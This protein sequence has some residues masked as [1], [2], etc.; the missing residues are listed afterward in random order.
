MV[1]ISREAQVGAPVR[2]DGPH[3]G[4]GLPKDDPPAVRGTPVEGLSP[5][6]RAGQDTG[7]V[8]PTPP[9]PRAQPQVCTTAPRTPVS[10]ALASSRPGGTYSAPTKRRGAMSAWKRSR[11]LLDLLSMQ[12]QEPF[13]PGRIRRPSGVNGIIHVPKTTLALELFLWQQPGLTLL[14][15]SSP[16]CTYS[17]SREVHGTSVNI[18]NGSI[19]A[20]F[21]VQDCKWYFYLLLSIYLFIKCIR[22]SIKEEI[23]DLMTCTIIRTQR[24]RYRHQI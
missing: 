1:L 21:Q 19:K 3:L 13:S 9:P 8:L 23:R 24:F 14:R 18:N 4:R 17:T 7:R 6:C 20:P 10:P 16:I 2:A 22:K 5:V 12:T 11:F 15:A